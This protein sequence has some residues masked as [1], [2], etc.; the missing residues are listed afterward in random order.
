MKF[1]LFRLITPY[2]GF[3]R[4]IREMNQPISD[5]LQNLYVVIYY[6]RK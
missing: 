2:S 1:A 3:S 6:K 5:M 4:H